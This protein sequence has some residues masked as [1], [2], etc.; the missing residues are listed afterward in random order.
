MATKLNGKHLVIVESP[1]KARTLERYLGEDFVV[2]A[3]VGHVV[4]LPKSG[5]GVDVESGFEPEYVP[6]RGKAQVLASLRRAA[7]EASDVLLATDPDREGEAIAYH[8]ARQLGLE[9]GSE[10]CRRITFNEIT[11]TA[12]LAAIEHPG[13]I[14]VRRFE[15]QQARR[16]LDRLVG[17]KLSPLLWKK[18]SPVD[19]VSRRTLSAG[20]VQSVAVRLAVERERERRA[21][22]S[23]SYWDLNAHLRSRGQAFTGD[24]VALGGRRLATGKDFDEATGRLREGRGVLQLNERA[25]R[26]LADRLAALPF[27]VESIEES[28]SVRRPYPPFT[29]SSLQQE[30]NRKLNLLAGDTMRTA[31]RLYEAGHITYMRTDS[32]QLSSQAI[33]AARACAQRRYG[34]EFLSP[35]PRRFKT[36]AKGAQ[37][38][39]EAIR[40]AGTEMKTASELRLSGREAALYDLIW[41]RT[42]ATQMADARWRHVKATIA[43]DDARFRASGKVLEF[44]GF[45]RAYVEGSDDP[46]AVLEDRETVLPPLEEGE[47][48]ECAS[49]EP[50][51]H[52][53][54]PPARY[55]E[56]SLVKAL[57]AEGI[58]RPSTYAKIMSN[59]VER[60]YV[61]RAGKQLVP[62]YLAF[63]VTRLLEEHFPDL[64]DPGFTAAMEEALDE[65]AAG[66][67]E[68]R[69]YLREFYSGENGFESRLTERESQI[70]PRTASTLR[71]SDLEPSVRIGRYGPFLEMERD[72]EK[73]T[74]SIPDDIAPAD[75]SNEQAIALLA[76]RAA[77]PT[78][79]G[80]DP[81]SGLGVFRMNGRFGPYVQLGEA[82]EDGPK[83]KRASLLPGMEPENVTLELALK[84]ISLPR[85]LGPHPDDGTQ[86]RA[87]VG[88]Y[89]PYVVHAG[90]FR[91]LKPGDD[92]L[93]IGLERALELLAEPKKGRRRGRKVEPLREIGAHPD[94]GEPV[95]LFEGRY[96]PYVKHGKENAS[97]P[98]GHD[99]E[100]VTLEDAVQWLAEKATRPRT[101]KGKR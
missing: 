80:T 52:E 67:L 85:D 43:A 76:E 78:L 54:K 99:V 15:A 38:A 35:K 93:E 29:T 64:V 32:V 69:G 8:I 87:G 73:V 10:R 31:Q 47:V 23:A 79:L 12:V 89:G 22:R 84:L 7:R 90:D 62:T 4:D 70:D 14:D 97:L 61:R 6:I 68:W 19:P 65:V 37:E 45:Y 66:N 74:A 71:L 92:V 42:L 16:I 55:T 81:D 46:D 83:P 21:F 86:V 50:V 56:A 75:L 96:G 39:H 24:L 63:A 26:E 5:L 51:S 58:G 13:E 1:Q 91:S 60:G 33:E 25:V 9:V 95:L 30:A 2:E 94:D 98:K 11:R 88:R 40:P 82:E 3:S 27:R 57:E 53:T 59:I 72:G 28:R 34:A 20:R 100:S 18:I 77:G 36:T 41:K 49:L 44:A 17:Y 48:L 101:R